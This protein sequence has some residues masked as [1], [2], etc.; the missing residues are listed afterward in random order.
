M[1]M[2]VPARKQSR[3]SAYGADDVES[4]HLANR[5]DYG[6]RQEGSALEAGQKVIDRFLFWLFFARGAKGDFWRFVVRGK[7][8]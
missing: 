8:S 1:D 4:V 7:D 5:R 6:L 3:R 2:Q